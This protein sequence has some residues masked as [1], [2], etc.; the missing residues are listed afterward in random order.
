ML[1]EYDKDE[2]DQLSYDC[3]LFQ[4]E[5]KPHLFIK[6]NL[7]ALAEPAESRRLSFE[8]FLNGKKLAGLP[9][10][11]GYLTGT[12][13]KRHLQSIYAS[14]RTSSGKHFA[15]I[16]LTFCKSDNADV[17]KEDLIKSR[18]PERETGNPFEFDGRDLHSRIHRMN[19]LFKVEVSDRKLLKRM[20]DRWIDSST[21]EDRHGDDVIECFRVGRYIGLAVP[22]NGGYKTRI[23]DDLPW[24]IK[25]LNN[26]YFPSYRFILHELSNSV[27][28]IQE[29]KYCGKE[30]KK[31][32][33]Y[34]S[35]GKRE[36]CKGGLCKSRY[37]KFKNLVE[38][39]YREGKISSWYKS[40]YLNTSS[41]VFK[42]ILL[43]SPGKADFKILDS[44]DIIYL[45]ENRRYCLWCGKEMEEKRTGARFCSD[46]CRYKY[47]ND[48]KMKKNVTESSSEYY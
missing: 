39:L 30:I 13:R 19:S 22:D 1:S 32:P 47:H 24:V 11:V 5:D 42:N 48:Q 45:K 8:E 25:G 3:A 36:F 17:I 33:I 27:Y 4:D 16:L 38:K 9:Y 6:N 37:K 23:L 18:N 26:Q 14:G 46:E 20:M 41:S 21:E 12:L 31:Y 34:T 2:I 7:L 40:V 35:P 28:Q 15:D 43:F 44:G 29:C 10:V